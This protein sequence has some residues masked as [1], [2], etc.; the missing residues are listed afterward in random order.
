MLQGGLE[1]LVMVVSGQV[2]PDM[3]SLGPLTDWQAGRVELC[4]CAHAAV[5]D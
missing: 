2:C 3:R 5:R 1:S 4:V